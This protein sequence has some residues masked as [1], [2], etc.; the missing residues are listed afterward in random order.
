MT[1]ASAILRDS[2]GCRID[3]SPQFHVDHAKRLVGFDKYGKRVNPE[4]LRKAKKL[5]QLVK[6]AA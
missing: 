4:E 1:T 2:Q 6:E 5:L 3:L